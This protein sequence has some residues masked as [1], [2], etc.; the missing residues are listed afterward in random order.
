L[1]ARDEPRRPLP[2]KL[3]HA[4]LLGPE[5]SHPDDP[6][7]GLRELVDIALRAIAEP[8]EDPAT[9]VQAA[10]RVHDCRRQLSNLPFPSGEYRDREVRLRLVVKILPWQGYARLAFDGL[11]LASANSIQVHRRMRAALEDVLAV[12]PPERRPPLDRQLDLLTAAARRNFEDADDLRAALE[13]DRQG[14]GFGAD[15]LH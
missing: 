9:A 5:R 10:D 13:P 14:I 1:L 4:V 7:F 11:R 12:A 8:F 6:A 3:V 15:L 2:P